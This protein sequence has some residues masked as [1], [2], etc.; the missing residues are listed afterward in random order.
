MTRAQRGLGLA[1]VVA[2]TA[3]VASCRSG[4]EEDPVDAAAKPAGEANAVGNRAERA[5]LFDSIYHKTLA[6]ESFAP[7][8][9]R[10]LDI[11]IDP[12]DVVLEHFISVAAMVGYLGGRAAVAVS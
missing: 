10:R 2:F 6:R 4:T 1:V 5:A 9:N 3:A 8:K 7:I 12:A 11:D